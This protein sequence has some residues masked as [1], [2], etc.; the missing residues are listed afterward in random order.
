MSDTD[1]ATQPNQTNPLSSPQ[2]AGKTVQQPL[3]NTVP[4]EKSDK[5]E[6]PVSSGL[7]NKEHAPMPIAS[8]ADREGHDQPT[9]EDGED[10]VV[11]QA[12]SAGEVAVSP[13]L[14]EVGVESKPNAE[15]PQVSEEVK[16]AGV[17]LAK[18]ATPVA[19]ATAT[20]SLYPL[21]NEEAL[22]IKKKN[23]FKIKDSITWFATQVSYLWKK[24][25][26]EK[27]EKEKEAI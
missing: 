15:T 14:Q 10:V 9:V 25:A 4:A 6:T 17:T 26:Q 16:A 1:T 13:E 21:T 24:E 18:D 8:P 20:P 7:G 2:P 11:Q 5:P 19:P 12:A 27:A 23:R 3:T 22:E